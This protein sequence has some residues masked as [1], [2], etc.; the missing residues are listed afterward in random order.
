MHPAPDGTSDDLPEAQ[1]AEPPAP[2]A[3]AELPDTGRR[4]VEALTEQLAAG[5]VETLYSLQ[6]AAAQLRRH[7]A[8]VTSA[9]EAVAAS[10]SGFSERVANEVSQGFAAL[11][12]EA[13]ASIGEHLTTEVEASTSELRDAAQTHAQAV[14]SQ[15]DATSGHLSTVLDAAVTR[16]D[17]ARQ[18]LEW[19]AQQGA[20]QLVAAADALADHRAAGEAALT[21]AGKQF[22]DQVATAGNDVL[23]HLRD[24]LQELVA[25]AGQA[26]EEIEQVLRDTRAAAETELTALRQQVEAAE[27]RE[28]S[29]G[30]RLQAH[31]E[32]LVARTDATVSQSLTH[33]RAVADALLERDAMLERR[34]VLQEGGAST[35]RLRDRIF[36]GM[37]VAKE[38]PVARP[39]PAP[40]PAA[41]PTPASRAAAPKAGVPEP[42]PA[43]A[44]A[45]KAAPTKV[46]A[47]KAPAKKAPTK[48]PAKA[49]ANKAAPTKVTAAKA[50]AKKRPAATPAKAAPELTPEPTRA[51]EEQA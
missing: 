37:A 18:G 17:D 44:P 16:T 32:Q 26:R 14:A 39:A 9:S 1:P 43:P 25:Q 38:Q 24:G 21:V 13:T 31:V 35:K 47:A 48:A 45:K 4:L 19:V 29:V 36:R 33:L 41:E 6:T 51:Q 22:A 3:A 5:Q 8:A 15:L 30:E 12:R 2:E 42:P 23:Q 7:T 11:L 46:T 27:R 40:T 20:Q 50:P 49:A 10:L 34:T 28:E